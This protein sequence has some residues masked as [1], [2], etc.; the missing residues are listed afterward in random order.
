MIDRRILLA[1]LLSGCAHHPARIETVTV[2][3][4]VPVPCIAAADIPTKPAPLSKMPDDA[5]AALAAALSSL[6]D[7]Q[8]YSIAADGALY[9][10]ATVAPATNPKVP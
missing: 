4:P 9:A 6:L 8:A 5:N 7:W 3:V 10:C 2:N 1:L